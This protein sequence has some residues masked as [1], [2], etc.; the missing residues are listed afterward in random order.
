[1]TVFSMT[2][3][4]LVR[5]SA[6]TILGCL[7]DVEGLIAPDSSAHRNVRSWMGKIDKEGKAPCVGEKALTDCFESTTN[8]ADRDSV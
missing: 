6:G 2:A 7:S 4:E 3:C 1:M 5:I 8:K